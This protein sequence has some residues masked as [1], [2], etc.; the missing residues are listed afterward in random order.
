[1]DSLFGITG[2]GFLVLKPGFGFIVL[3][4]WFWI[5]CFEFL[6]WDYV[7][8]IPGFGLRGGFMVSG[9]LILSPG[10]GFIV[11]NSHFCIT[12]I[13]TKIYN[14]FQASFVFVRAKA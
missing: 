9:S 13:V 6:V 11:L 8:W 14:P 5:P 3:D 4:S 2:F 7:F 12:K 10:F 1:M